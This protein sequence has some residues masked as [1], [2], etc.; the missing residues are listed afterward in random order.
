MN[1]AISLKQFEDLALAVGNQTCLF[2]VGEA[3]IGKTA[4]G[5][6]IFERGKEIILATIS[7]SCCAPIHS[8][9]M[10][11]LREE[12]QP[13]PKIEISPKPLRETFLPL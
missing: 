11:T 9:S 10:L 6:N 1:T 13:L 3:G 12:E 7:S 8:S 4:T 2:M 5:A